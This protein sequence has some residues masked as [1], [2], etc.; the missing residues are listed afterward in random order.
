MKKILTSL[1]LITASFMLLFTANNVFAVEYDDLFYTEGISFEVLTTDETGWKAT[2]TPGTFDKLYNLL[3]ENDINESNVKLELEVFVNDVKINAE[4]YFNDYPTGIALDLYGEGF[5]GS[6]LS[7]IIEDDTV[8]SYFPPP[9]PTLLVGDIVT[10]L[11]PELKSWTNAYDYG[12]IRLEDTTRNMYLNK[13]DNEVFLSTTSP[14]NPNPENHKLFLDQPYENDK[15]FEIGTKVTLQSPYENFKIIHGSA[16]EN[17]IVQKD[18]VSAVYLEKVAQPT[19]TERI[20]DITVFYWEDNE[21][22]SQVVEDVDLFGLVNLRIMFY[23]NIRKAISG[24]AAIIGNVDDNN[25]IDYYLQ[26]LT[27][28]DDIDGD[29]SDSIYVIEYGDYSG[30]VVGSYEVVVGVKDSEN[31]ESIFEFTAVVADMVSPIL[32]APNLEQTV[33]AEQTFNFT[34]YLASLVK[35]D[36]YYDDDDI[37]ITIQSNEYTANKSIPGTYNVVLRVKDPSLNYT[38]YTLEI[39]VIDETPPQ[40]TQGLTTLSK[41]IN[42][43]INTAQIIATQRAVDAVD[44][45]VSDS[46]TI[47]SNNYQGNETTPGNYTIVIKAVDAAGNEATKTITVEV[48]SAPPGWYIADDGPIIIPAGSTLTFEQIRAVLILMGWI[49]EEDDL[50]LVSSNYFGNEGTPGTYTLS[51]SVNGNNVTYNLLVL[52]QDD[53]FF[54]DIPDVPQQSSFNPVWILAIVGAITA[55]GLIYYFYKKK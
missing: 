30:A 24:E 10:I 53:D 19:S 40:F 39:T 7:S 37:T 16:G 49:E 41:S 54:P 4:L 45:D 21:L 43:E 35:S 6:V 38:D 50:E 36:N 5:G 12:R 13:V 44:G 31:Q 11:E 26:F 42:E 18:N 46:I 22:L 1:M 32:V 15:N 28:W 9:S 23:G 2:L 20:Y 14:D 33:N 17:V 34:T 29:I 3:T 48:F 47:V 8:Q 55:T 27:A 51:L 25:D 52:N